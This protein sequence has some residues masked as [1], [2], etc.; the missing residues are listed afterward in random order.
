MDIVP[1]FGF[2]E[3]VQLLFILLCTFLTLYIKRSN[4]RPL[5]LLF[6][7]SISTQLHKT[8]YH[9]PILTIHQQ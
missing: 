2:S 7:S 3:H 4:N 5:L 6:Q 8:Q 9:S 1:W